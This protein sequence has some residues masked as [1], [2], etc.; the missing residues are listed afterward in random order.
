M[1]KEKTNVYDLFNSQTIILRLYGNIF[2]RSPG[3]FG[4]P[5]TVI[6]VKSVTQL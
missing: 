5:C 1:L 3:N 4:I 2:S 6:H